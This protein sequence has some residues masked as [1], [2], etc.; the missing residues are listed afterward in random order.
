MNNELDYRLIKELWVYTENHISI[1]FEYE[2]HDADTGQQL[3]V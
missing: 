2:R 3:E 1:R